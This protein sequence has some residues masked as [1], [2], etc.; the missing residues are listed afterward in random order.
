MGFKDVVRKTA[1]WLLPV[2]VVACSLLAL[3]AAF[4]GRTA[5]AKDITVEN[6]VLDVRR[7]DMSSTV[8]EVTGQWDFYPGALYDPSDFAAGTVGEKAG[9]DV[10]PSDWA[11]GTHRL[12]I[13]APPDR[14][15][16]R[17]TMPPA[18]L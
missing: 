10:S 12:R 13:Q 5:S 1:H 4:F 2:V 18:S 17:W 3:A 9:Q 16:S 7:L 15:Y 14:Y 8:F 6:G 11:Y